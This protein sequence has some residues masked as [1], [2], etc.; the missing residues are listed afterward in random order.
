[1]EEKLSLATL[2][3]CNLVQ[4]PVSYFLLKEFDIRRFFSEHSFFSGQVPANS[5][6]LSQI[7]YGQSNR[8]I[9]H[10]TD[11]YQICWRFLKL[12]DWIMILGPY[13]TEDL[14][15]Q[16]L[17]Q[18]ASRNHIDDEKLSNFQIY[19]NSVT[20]IPESTITAASYTVF[21]HIYGTT[22]NIQS[23]SI[24]VEEEDIQ[25]ESDY[26]ITPAAF[27]ER[28]HD[29][30]AAYME[31]IA[32]GSSSDA[33]LALQQIISRTSF[34]PNNLNKLWI[35]KMG[36]TISRTEGRLALKEIGVPSPILDNVS[37]EY[38]HRTINA[39]TE[40]EVTQVQKVLTERYCEIARQYRLSPYSLSIRKAIHYIY[41]HMPDPFSVADVAAE[42]GLSPNRLSTNFHKETGST[43]S[44]YIR[45]AR[46]SRAAQH[47][48][49]TT[50]NI[51]KICSSVGIP[52]SNYFARIFKQKYGNTPS[53]YR[54][55]LP[56]HHP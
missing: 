5:K 52:D 35:S 14:S 26:F 15:R 34:R 49:N 20:Q 7:I 13:R 33:L 6:I 2:Y 19:C 45:D 46:L 40:E 29:L 50:W 10:L 28:T 3:I 48:L 51:Q 9:F 12:D 44:S 22:H 41:T 11:A 24:S 55:R 18:I 8:C 21:T 54:L 37:R 43:L 56:P 16:K 53:D 36:A 39:S 42:A 27:V 17:H 38:S 31:A 1:M 30:E 32:T 25:M 47:L 4:I 23:S